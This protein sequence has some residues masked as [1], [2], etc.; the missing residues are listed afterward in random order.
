MF[1]QY[2]DTPIHV[3]NINT[4]KAAAHVL[5]G[6]SELDFDFDKYDQESVMSLTFKCDYC[7]HTHIRLMQ[8]YPES[9]TY[10]FKVPCN[11][12]GEV[13]DMLVFRNKS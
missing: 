11:N 7:L 4:D 5:K 10:L 6:T 1:N 2:A 12:C 13:T 9:G 8:G 3:E